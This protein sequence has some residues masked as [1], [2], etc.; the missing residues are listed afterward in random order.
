VSLP[1]AAL[2]KLEIISCAFWQENNFVNALIQFIWVRDSK[3]T[4]LPFVNVGAKQMLHLLC[5]CCHRDQ[6]RA[7]QMKLA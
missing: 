4:D 7:K 6:R 2:S 1:I 5:P 3:N